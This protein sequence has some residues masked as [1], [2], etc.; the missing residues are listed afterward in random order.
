MI[1]SQ[2]RTTDGVAVALREAEALALKRR[3][4]GCTA[5][6]E[7]VTLEDLRNGIAHAENVMNETQIGKARIPYQ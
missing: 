2:V 5:T 1:I 3:L 6:A 4:Q 7:D